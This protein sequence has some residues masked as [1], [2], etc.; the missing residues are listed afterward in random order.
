MVQ[1]V[2]Y[3]ECSFRSIL[4]GVLRTGRGYCDSER[5]IG[6]DERKGISCSFRSQPQYR[7]LIFLTVDKWY[8]KKKPQ[9][10][11]RR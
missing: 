4:L 3:K 6:I 10:Q 8:L 2:R 11:R 5:G 7:G 1:T 9:E